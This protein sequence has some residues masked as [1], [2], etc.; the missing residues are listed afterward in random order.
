MIRRMPPL[1]ALKAFEAA[2]RH[3]SF[4]KASEELSVTQAAISHQVR[5]L[6][7][8]FGIAM[9]NR[10]HQ[11]LTLT[12]AGKAYLPKLT[13]AFDLVADGYKDLNK[14]KQFSIL[15]IKAP[16]SFSVQWL[17]PR[18]TQFQITNPDV[19]IRLSAQDNDFDFFPEAFDIEIRYLLGEDD[20]P[21]SDLLFKEEIFPV[22]SPDLIS[23]TNPLREPEDLASHTLLHINFYPEDWEM[24]LQQVGV[25]CVDCERG[26]RFDQSVLT[27]NA[28]AQG[29]GVAIGRTPIVN[30]QLTS[31]S[32]IE[33]F[34]N[35]LLSKGGYW[36]TVKTDLESRQHVDDFRS[37]I[38]DESHLEHRDDHT[39]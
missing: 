39:I 16:S 32:L 37:W 24:W 23:G 29:L 27:L 22:C 3:L 5:T 26:H 35:R 8:Y 11:R 10:S 38:L 4:T 30:Q 15:N 21:N 6:E 20:N 25:S 1:N 19:Y 2:A 33:P 9:F 7:E 34:N 13:Q 36:L 18:L 12:A 14:D 31:G 28:A 17:V